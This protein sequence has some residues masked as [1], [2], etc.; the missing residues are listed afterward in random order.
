MTVV[1]PEV[2]AAGLLS[3]GRLDECLSIYRRLREPL[4][5]SAD[6]K[7]RGN[8]ALRRGDTKGALNYFVVSGFLAAEF[9]TS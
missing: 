1:D 4:Q 2:V 6:L 3:A 5:R 8:E 9:K 7:E